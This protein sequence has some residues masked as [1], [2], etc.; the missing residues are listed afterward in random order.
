KC[1]QRSNTVSNSV[2]RDPCTRSECKL[3]PCNLDNDIDPAL[4]ILHTRIRPLWGNVPPNNTPAHSRC[5]LYR[6][7]SRP[8]N[9]WARTNDLIH[10]LWLNHRRTSRNRRSHARHSQESSETYSEPV[11]TKPD[12][13]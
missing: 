1:K 7:R 4:H 9:S 11:S 2:K 13:R 12:V 10:D 8:S 6:R 3:R 5:W